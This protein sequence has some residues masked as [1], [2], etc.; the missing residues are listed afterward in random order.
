MIKEG[1]DNAVAE[2]MRDFY[3]E[4]ETHYLHHQFIERIIKMFDTAEKTAWRV[5]IS[6]IVIAV[7]TLI[8]AGFWDRIKSMF[9]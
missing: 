2:K 7:L 1:L 8:V 5:T 9:G 3:I 4:R 6:F